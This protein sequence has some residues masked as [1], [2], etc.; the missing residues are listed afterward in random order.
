VSTVEY[1]VVE[2][3]CFELLGA[4]ENPSFPKVYQRLGHRGSAQVVQDA[5]TQ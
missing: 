4:G 5:I 1:E 2:Q 3:A